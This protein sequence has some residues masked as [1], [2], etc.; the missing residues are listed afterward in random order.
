MFLDLVAAC[1]NCSRGRCTE[2]GECCSSYC[3][4]GCTGINSNECFACE[5]VVW[6]NQCVEK[7]PNAYYE[8]SIT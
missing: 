5:K 3:L 8:V 4:G 6:E 1:P 7:C 2:N